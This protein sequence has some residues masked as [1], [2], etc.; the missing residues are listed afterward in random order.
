MQQPQPMLVPLP[1]SERERLQH[2]ATVLRKA[3]TAQSRRGWLWAGTL[4]SLAISVRWMFIAPRPT[5]LPEEVSAWAFFAFLGLG[6]WACDDHVK[7]TAREKLGAAR[8]ALN[9]KGLYVNYDGS[10]VHQYLGPGRRSVGLD[11][12]DSDAYENP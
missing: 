6:A 11:P 2:C 4:L 8:D 3:Y 7:I 5:G 12:L 10:K 9:A 1:M